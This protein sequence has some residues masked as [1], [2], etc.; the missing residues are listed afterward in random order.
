M[1]AIDIPDS[2]LRRAK[3]LAESEGITLDQFIMIAVAG[4]VASFNTAY[5]IKESRKVTTD[6]EQDQLV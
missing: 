3:S 1:T 2:L 5:E 6:R 4:Q